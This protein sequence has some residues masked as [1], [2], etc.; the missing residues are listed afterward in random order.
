MPS[1]KRSLARAV[2]GGGG[3]AGAPAVRRWTTRCPPHS[4]AATKPGPRLQT[5]WKKSSSR[6]Y[7]AAPCRRA[8]AASTRAARPRLGT[9]QP[10]IRRASS[11]CPIR[12]ASFAD[13]T[14]APPHTGRALSLFVCL[15]HYS[16]HRSC[17]ASSMYKEV[18]CSARARAWDRARAGGGHTVGGS[19][20]AHAVSNQTRQRHSTR[21]CTQHSAMAVRL[22][23]KQSHTCC[24]ET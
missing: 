8:D 6:R 18:D 19:R 2:P 7:L 1:M 22:C 16:V 24:C 11:G 4:R 5:R 21:L 14:C 23:C 12:P 20:H 10:M 3:T 15:C 9:R 17:C 13:G